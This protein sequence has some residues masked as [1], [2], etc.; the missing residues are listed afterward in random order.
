MRQNEIQAVWHEIYQEPSASLFTR[1]LW[2]TVFYEHSVPSINAVFELA[3]S[4]NIHVVRSLS[5]F[6]TELF[7]DWFILSCIF[8]TA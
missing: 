5:L 7:E 6:T 2:S 8:C 3:W 1:L 4:F